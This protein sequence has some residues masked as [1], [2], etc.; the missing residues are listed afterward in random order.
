M[1]KEL[2]R[3]IYGFNADALNGCVHIKEKPMFLYEHL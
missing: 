3:K 2:K 1:G